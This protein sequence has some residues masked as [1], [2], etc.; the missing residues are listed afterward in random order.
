[1][2]IPKDKR[3]S[4]L[5]P[6]HS[7]PRHRIIN[8][9]TQQVENIRIP[10]LCRNCRKQSENILSLLSF[11]QGETCGMEITSVFNSRPSKV[12][13]KSTR[14]WMFS[15]NKVELMVCAWTVLLGYMKA[16]ANR[17]NQDNFCR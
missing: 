16:S 4:N 3:R 8:W 11:S 15:E 14:P 10:R 6:R 2:H 13:V 17:R 12:E 7:K 1:M 9:H 5:F